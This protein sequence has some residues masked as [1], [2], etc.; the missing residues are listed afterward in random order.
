MVEKSSRRGGG[1]GNKSDEGYAT[2]EREKE[3]SRPQKP[4]RRKHL[5]VEKQNKPW[6]ADEKNVGNWTFSWKTKW[7]HDWSGDQKKWFVAAQHEVEAVMKKAEKKKLT[8]QLK[9]LERYD[10]PGRWEIVN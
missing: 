2:K 3:N 7:N 1:G 6:T 4:T 8:E 10:K 9:A 5:E